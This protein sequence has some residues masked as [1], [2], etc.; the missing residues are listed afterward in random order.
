MKV[1]RDGSA[2]NFNFEVIHN[3]ATIFG[4]ATPNGDTWA[5]LKLVYDGEYISCFINDSSTPA[6]KERV[7]IDETKNTYFR[8]QT[9]QSITYVDF[10]D[11][12]VFREGASSI[13]IGSS[14]PV[15]Q[16]GDTASIT[17]SLY[18][19]GL[20][21]QNAT[22]DVYKNGTKVGTASTGSTG[23]ASYTYTGV[24][25]GEVE[26]QFKY[27]SISSE[28]FVVTDCI[29]Y[30]GGTSNTSHLSIWNTT[31]ATP[32]V[33]PDYTSLIYDNAVIWHTCEF[34]AGSDF[35][36]EFDVNITTTNR[37]AYDITIRN[38]NQDLLNYYVYSDASLQSDNWYHIICRVENNMCTSSNDGTPDVRSRDITGYSKFVFNC[39]QDETVRYKNFKIY[40]I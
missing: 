39:R 35:I 5:D 14:T 13:S 4:W 26:F 10:K 15:I 2:G 24:A 18:E 8:L 30:D 33:T 22:L 23:V 3:N 21:V 31:G 6:R 7:Y 29:K 16:S 40:P 25:D 37:G 19:S 1:R 9:P 11:L 28:T 12:L 20:P 38:A 32:Q 34:N 17:G 27:G 36:L